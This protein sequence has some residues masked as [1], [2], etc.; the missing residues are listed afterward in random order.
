MTDREN[1]VVFLVSGIC[2]LLC[3]PAVLIAEQTGFPDDPF[4]IIATISTPVCFLCGLSFL[5]RSRKQPRGHRRALA[6]VGVILSGG[7]ICFLV[8]VVGLLC[9]TPI[10]EDHWN[11]MP[12]DSK[13]WKNPDLA[14]SVD[15]PRLRMVDDLLDSHDDLTGMTK[16]QI[17]DLLGPEFR[18]EISPAETDSIYHLGPQRHGFLRIDSEWLRISFSDGKVGKVRITTD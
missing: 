9:V 15:Y 10:I 5:I 7:W 18:G 13:V 1:F 17:Y 11:R 12:F 6:K 4:N 14:S 16:Q 8:F 3:I 2:A